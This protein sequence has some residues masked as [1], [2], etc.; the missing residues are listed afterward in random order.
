MRATASK[1]G[2]L[3]LCGWWARDD[4]E[5]DPFRTSDAADRGNRFH[6]AIAAFEADGELREYDADIALEMTSAM[7][8]LVE[9]GIKREDIEVERALGWDFASDAGVVYHIEH[10]DYPN[11]GLLHGTVD[12][13][14]WTSDRTIDLWDWKTGDGSSSGPQLRALAM[15]A[16]RAYGL[17]EV[18]IGALEVKASGVTI[19]CEETLDAFALD[20]VAGEL[21]EHVTAV[22]NAE[23]V[24]GSHCSDL[25][26]PARLSCPLGNAATAELVDVIP[27]DSL[28]RTKPFRLTDPIKTPEHAAWALD[29]LR[30][31]VAKVDALK[32]EIKAKVPAEGWK[33]E[34]GRML[35]ETKA[36]VSYV[37]KDMAVSLARRLGATEQDVESCTKS[38]ERS[39]GLRI[40]GGNTKPRTRRGKAA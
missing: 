19:V 5:Q 14:V 4:A 37:D 32:D 25:Y 23:P 40:T 11:D 6:S 34:D 28:V 2:L 31:V 9:R 13:I 12:L 38:F 24:P 16:A 39:N 1:V 7:T 3:G 36:L 22:E 35:K 29:V 15:M 33:L 27:A 30:L 21:A 18:R 17:T 8:W 20:A 26:C 10:R